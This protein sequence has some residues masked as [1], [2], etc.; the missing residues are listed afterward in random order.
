[1][2]VSPPTSL[3]NS[4]TNKVLERQL[5]HPNLE[6]RAELGDIRQS[7]IY[8]YVIV[9]LEP[10]KTLAVQML[11]AGAANIKSLSKAFLTSFCPWANK[12]IHFIT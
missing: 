4:L 2:T 6:L 12:D 10:F 8:R 11:L 9:K 1:M 5:V 3:F 7:I